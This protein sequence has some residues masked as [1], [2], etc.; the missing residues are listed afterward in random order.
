MQN[1]K[2]KKRALSLFFV[3]IILGAVAVR[4]SNIPEPYQVGMD[5]AFQE[6]LA[7]SHLEYGFKKTH[8][9]SVVG[10]LQDRPI[11]HLSH[12]P[13]LQV[14]YAVGYRLF[15]VRE[16]VARSL[17]LLALLG[18][19]ILLYFS[20]VRVADRAVAGLAA[21]FVAFMPL[22][23][24]YSQTTFFGPLA[25]FFISLIYFAYV[26]WVAT[27]RRGFYLLMLGASV[28]G[29]LTEWTVYLIIPFIVLI[30]FLSGPGSR[31]ER[32][33]RILPLGITASL[34]ILLL[35][36]YYYWL[37]GGI[38]LLTHSLRRSDLYYLLQ[39]DFYHRLFGHLL[40]L[41]P[42]CGPLALVGLGIFLFK[43]SR[44][45][46]FISLLG[47]L[48]LPLLYILLAPQLIYLHPFELYYFVPFLAVFSAL[49]LK[50]LPAR[51]SAVILV[52]FLLLANI[53]NYRLNNARNPFYYRLARMVGGIYDPG[54]LVFS[55]AAVGHFRFYNRMPTYWPLGENEPEPE[56]FLQSGTASFALIDKTNPD[57]RGLS[58]NLTRAAEENAYRLLYSFPSAELYTNKPG[59]PR[60]YSFATHLSEAE[61]LPNGTVM[62]QWAYPRADLIEIDEEVDYS[63]YQ[64]PA[65]GG[66]RLIY[67]ERELLPDSRLL[68]S[69]G[70]D[71]QVCSPGKGDGVIFEITA[72][73]SIVF[74]RYID[75][76]NNPGERKWHRFSLNLSR[77]SGKNFSFTTLPGKDNS[78][79]SAYWGGAI[80]VH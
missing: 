39:G 10:L 51:A 71:P 35:L 25:L 17:S 34:T 1:E 20:L 14:I 8:L 79:D 61:F 73:E 40:R 72:G 80:I 12:P 22:S 28:L 42:I 44:T 2:Y 29:G 77:W 3:L 69:I 15:G 27:E 58:E 59:L 24:A 26:S 37:S 70:L 74:S 38:P 54:D 64:H 16:A 31:G 23:V 7:L 56:W 13:L 6:A 50:G 41:S 45:R 63:L 18:T 75:P 67:P 19:L 36:L 78:Y 53:I 49:A 4:W 43:R 52:G 62:P 30:H 57:V 60:G 11:Y 33:K 32:F 66:S 5:S 46:S 55:T 76:K 21:A 48:G 47:F 9:V 65:G 68:F